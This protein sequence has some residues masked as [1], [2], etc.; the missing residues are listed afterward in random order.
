MAFD[1]ICN[2]VDDDDEEKENAFAYLEEDIHDDIR[3]DRDME[4]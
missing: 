2:F 3:A 4:E 1:Y